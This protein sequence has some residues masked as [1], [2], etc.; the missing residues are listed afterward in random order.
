MNEGTFPLRDM[1]PG[2]PPPSERAAHEERRLCYVAFSRAQHELLVTHIGLGAKQLAP[3]SS[4]IA[5]RR[6]RELIVRE[7]QHENDDESAARAQSGE[8]SGGGDAAAAFTCAAQVAAAA[9]KANEERRTNPL[10]QWIANPAGG[11]QMR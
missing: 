6:M 5:D 2:A 7:H 8:Q 10:Q 9:A 3:I 4:F 1:R 11:T